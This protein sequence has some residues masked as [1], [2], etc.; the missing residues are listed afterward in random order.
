[1]NNDIKNEIN[2]IEI[3]ELETK[4]APSSGSWFLD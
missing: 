2:S 4:V 1:M 3:E